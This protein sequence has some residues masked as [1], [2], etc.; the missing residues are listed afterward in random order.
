MISSYDQSGLKMLHVK[1]VIHE[2]WV[3]WMYQLT[4]DCGS[5]WSRYIWLTM[6]QRIP[7]GLFQGLCQLPESALCGLDNFYALMV[8]SYA[9]VNDLFYKKSDELQLPINI[10]CHPDSPKINFN[11]SHAGFNTLYDL[12]LT[13]ENKIDFWLVQ[14]KIWST[15]NKNNYNAF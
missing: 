3:K 15:R 1:N 13:S 11:M 9:Y 6:C 14:N 2:L 12:P 8:H 4:E 7:A 10:F 5:T